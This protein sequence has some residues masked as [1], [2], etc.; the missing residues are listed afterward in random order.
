MSGFAFHIVGAGRG[1]T[2]L[3]GGLIDTHPDC[4]V[5]FEEFSMNFLMGRAWTDAENVTDPV[6]RAKARIA[7]F[8]EAC[9]ARAAAFPE[10]LWGHK[11]TTEQIGRIGSATG[12][13][14]GNDTDALDIFI[15]SVAHVPT[16]FILRDGRTCVRS[17]VSRTGQ[18]IESAIQGWKYSLRVMDAFRARA[19]DLLVVKFEEL[20]TQPEA[21]MRK[22]LAFLGVSYTPVVLPGPANQKLNPDYRYNFFG[23][24]KILIEQDTPDWIDDVRKELIANGYRE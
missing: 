19:T 2:S 22:V 18:P 21:T 8:V 15:D 6:L 12:H 7:N 23:V 13:D 24:S 16:I 11:T 3:I 9:E 20:I 10:K 5:H 4:E 14:L 17:K 1:G